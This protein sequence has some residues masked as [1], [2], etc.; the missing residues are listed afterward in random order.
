[1][2]LETKPDASGEMQILNLERVLRITLEVDEPHKKTEEDHGVI[3]AHYP[4]DAN[5]RSLE[6]IYWGEWDA[7]EKVYKMLLARLETKGQLLRVQQLA[8]AGRP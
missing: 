5:G 6:T 3:Y 4:D 2:W 7:C 8:N 1:M